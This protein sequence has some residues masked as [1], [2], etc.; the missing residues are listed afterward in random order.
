MSNRGYFMK[1]NSIQK[2]PDVRVENPIHFPPHDSHPERIQRIMLSS[3]RSEP[4]RESQKVLFVN[5]I[6]DRSHGV[7]N[8]FVI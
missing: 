7:L 6:K 4:I 8:D 1:W 2:A 5:L 3:P